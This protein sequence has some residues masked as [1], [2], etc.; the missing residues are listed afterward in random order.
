MIFQV[1]P[2]LVPGARSL[3]F[4]ELLHTFRPSFPADPK[5]HAPTEDDWDPCSTVK[6]WSRCGSFKLTHP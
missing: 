6:V 4:K 3:A 2:C 5:D 1:S